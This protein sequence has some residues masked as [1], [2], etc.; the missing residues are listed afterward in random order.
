MRE[1]ERQCSKQLELFSPQRLSKT[2]ARVQTMERCMQLTA[3]GSTPVMLAM[4]NANNKGNHD[5]V[6]NLIFLNIAAL[7]KYLHLNNPLKEAEAEDIASKVLHT[8][9][10]ALSFADLNLVLERAKNGY[11]GRFYERLSAPDVMSW[12]DSYYNERL[13]TAES[14]SYAEHEHSQPR[15]RKGRLS[16]AVA[17]AEILKAQRAMQ[18][19]KEIKKKTQATYDNLKEQLSKSGQQ[20]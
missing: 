19:P 10:G 6:L 8:Y 9:G 7:D 14:N 17:A 2:F 11:Y 16:E 1:L 13:N 4:A 5:A 15:E 20:S 12:F 18:S 3:E